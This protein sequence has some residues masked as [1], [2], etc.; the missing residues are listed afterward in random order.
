MYFEKS[1]GST[2]SR[3]Q[4][5]FN[6]RLSKNCLLRTKNEIPWENLGAS[7]P[8]S[9]SECHSG[10]QSEQGD[11]IPVGVQS[12]TPNEL[13]AGRDLKV[14]GKL[15]P[16]EDLAY[17]LVVEVDPERIRIRGAPVEADAELVTAGACS[18]IQ[19]R[20]SPTY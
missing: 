18:G 20:R 8:L 13:Q 5:P 7:V 12:R 17:P 4:T 3:Y 15:D 11:S 16:A 14:F 1:L 6:L 19:N 10:S 9:G 2:K